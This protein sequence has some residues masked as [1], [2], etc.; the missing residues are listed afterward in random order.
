MGKVILCSGNRAKHPYIFNSSHVRIYTMEELCYFVYNNIEAIGEELFREEL[1]VFIRDELG[2]YERAEFIEGLRKNQAGIKD[3]V[4]SILCS[5]D[6]YSEKEIKDLLFEMDLLYKLKPVQRKK[7]NADIL[8]KKDKYG[9]AVKEYRKILNLKEA[10]DLTS[11]EYGNIL[12]NIAV[13][14][15]SAGVFFS[16]AEGFREAYE[17]NHDKESLKQYLYALKLSKQDTLYEKEIDN[18]VRIRSLADEIE[19][20]VS[21]L[22]KYWGGTEEYMLYKYVLQLREQGQ[23]SEYYKKIDEILDGLKNKYR[24][25]C[26]WS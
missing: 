25:D 7:R 18:Y 8:M 4:V 20:D 24:K 26:I 15:A 14:D 16:A 3:I 10:A 11:V 19:S 9:E 13:A 2:L 1:T 22:D 6:Y 21:D 12:H 23:I 5:T 17:R